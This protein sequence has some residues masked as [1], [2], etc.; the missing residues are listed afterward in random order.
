MFLQHFAKYYKNNCKI[1]TIL[2][3]FPLGVHKKVNF[4]L[5]L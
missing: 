3:N 5:I 2:V 4:Y 1:K